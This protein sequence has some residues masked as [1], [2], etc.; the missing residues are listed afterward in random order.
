LI[1]LHRVLLT[2]VVLLLTACASV[3]DAPYEEIAA[4]ASDA[5]LE[6]PLLV[7]EE[8]GD[9]N[10][11]LQA[12]QADSTQYRDLW[13]RIR[14]GFAVSDLDK[15][16]QVNRAA[17]RF[18]ADKFL[19]RTA[20][21]AS[22]LL[23]YVVQEVDQRH[24]PMELVLVP[25]VESGYTLEAKSQAEAHGAWQ[26]IENTAK[27]YELNI[28]RFRDERRS[29]VSSTR[30][31]LDYLD[32]LHGMFNSWPL[33]MAAY[34]C[35]EK[36]IQAEID[37][38]RARR[39]KNPGFN[40]LAPYL[41]PETRDYVPRILALK[42]LI[43]DPGAFRISLPPID[44]AP[45]HSVVEIHRDVDV[46]LVARLA[47]LSM[48]EFQAINPSLQAPIIIGSSHTRLL[49]PHSAALRLSLNM[50]T[51]SGQW[52]SW[53]MV[54][55]TRATTPGEVAR[56]NGL[57]LRLVAQAN[58]LPEGHYYAVGSTLLLP[59]VR[60]K[61]APEEIDA[62]TANRAVLVTRSTEPCNVPHGCQ[63]TA[64]EPRSALAKVPAAANKASN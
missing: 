38:A 64:G 18:V 21:R 12:P 10:D 58:P 24:L 63:S 3:F 29:L 50:G 8:P 26:F 32:K 53:R 4:D 34:N 11:L 54:R 49:L 17:K 56:R 2:F 59:L 22:G 47:G 31:A 45:R 43:A 40:D 25:F 36:R 39:V 7:E 27:T 28:D 33:A 15:D 13:E 52:V 23:Y 14:Q 41:P 60:G 46:S 48:A 19:D 61:E 1:F 30:A 20:Q 51:Y 5:A 55:I 9:L 37:K 42:K 35:G 16:A 6:T 62:L 44:N 57:P